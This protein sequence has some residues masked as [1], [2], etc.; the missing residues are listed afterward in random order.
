MPWLFIMPEDKSSKAL[1]ILNLV[2]RLSG[3]SMRSMSSSMAGKAFTRTIF[4]CAG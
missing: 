3:M 1:L 2:A 4:D